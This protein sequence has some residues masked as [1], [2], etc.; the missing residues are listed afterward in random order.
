[1]QP[2]QQQQQQQQQQRV[3]GFATLRGNARRT[4][5]EQSPFGR[6]AAD[7][8]DDTAAAAAAR[9]RGRMQRA[10]AIDPLHPP[11]AA[12]VGDLLQL[13]ATA[14][15]PRTAAAAAAAA[16][17][18]ELR[19]PQLLLAK[20]TL[21]TVSGAE[22]FCLRG[23]S[24]AC[25]LLLH[26]LPADPAAAAAAAQ[27]AAAAAAAARPTL[28]GVSPLDMGQQQQQ[29]DDAN[30]GGGCVMLWG[31]LLEGSSAAAAAAAAAAECGAAT[32]LQEA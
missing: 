8:E 1:M 28:V 15:L 31:L 26:R 4:A 2:L 7:Y 16:D 20:K 24:D 18:N 17:F 11:G 21:E 14:P 30:A 22:S 19:A 32:D 3:A 23:D 13:K 10:A 5:A 9:G 12:C 27:A 29:Q 25:V 6:A